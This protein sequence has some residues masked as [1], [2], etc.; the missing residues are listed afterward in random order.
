MPRKRKHPS[1]QAGAPLEQI[2]WVTDVTVHSLSQEMAV[3]LKDGMRLVVRRD[4]SLELSFDSIKMIPR[5]MVRDLT[6]TAEV[7]QRFEAMAEPEWLEWLR[8]WAEPPP[9]MTFRGGRVVTEWPGGSGAPP[10]RLEVLGLDDTENWAPYYRGDRLRFAHFKTMEGEEGAVVQWYDSEKGVFE[11]P[12]VY[13]GDF[14]AFM[15]D[16]SRDALDAVDSPEF[17]TEINDSFEN[18]I[19]W[20]LEMMGAFDRPGTVTAQMLEVIAQDSELLL[21]ES[22]L[23]M[24]PNL[25]AYSEDVQRSLQDAAEARRLA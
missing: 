18:T 22:I 16:Q 6:R 20:A 12:L 7:Q 25:E 15:A 9:A 11:A 14:S 10:R 24:L 19:M 21:N 17:W 5:Y 13:L 8:H 23:K 4:G 2:P 1:I 3:L